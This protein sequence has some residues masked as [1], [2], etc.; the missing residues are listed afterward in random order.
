ML[1]IEEAIATV[2]TGTK[3]SLKLSLKSLPTSPYS[4]KVDEKDGAA[5][6][7]VWCHCLLTV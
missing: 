1:A 2:V 3:T 6:Q 5:W 7:C 4:P